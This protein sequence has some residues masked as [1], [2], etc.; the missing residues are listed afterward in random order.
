METTMMELSD[1]PRLGV[2]VMYNPALPEFLHTDLDALD[3]LEV[4]SDTLRT[5]RADQHAGVAV[6]LPYDRDVL[7]MIAERV[8]RVQQIA[9]IPLLLE[10]SVYFVSFRDQDMSEPQFL[11]ALTARTGCGILLDLHN[12]YCNA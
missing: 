9:S 3:Y 1:L 6:P 12:L 8:E 4:T 10:N 5:D 11:N 7:E 2:G